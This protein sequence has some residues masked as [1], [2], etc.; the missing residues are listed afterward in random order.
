M[1]F[2]KRL[3]DWFVFIDD[4]KPN[5]FDFSDKINVGIRKVYMQSTNTNV[6]AYCYCFDCVL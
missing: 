3:N 4:S 2:F 5:E 6:K 1:K